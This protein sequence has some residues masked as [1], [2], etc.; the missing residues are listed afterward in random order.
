MSNIIP[1]ITLKQPWASWVMK[2]LKTK[3]S[4]IHANFKTLVDKEFGIHAAMTYDLSDYV[5]KNPYLT[6]EQIDASLDYPL[7]EILGT[8]HCDEFLQLNGEQHEKEA[9]IECRSIKRY[10]LNLINPKEFEKP[11]PCKGELAIWYYDLD[12]MEKVRKPKE[13]I[14]TFF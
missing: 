13:E 7:G 12:T 5:L 2:R 4:R 14:P 3:E 1:V 11:I 9:L 6:Q 10:G 8:V